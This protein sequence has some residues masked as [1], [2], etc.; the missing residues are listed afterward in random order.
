MNSFVMGWLE[1]V[2]HFHIRVFKYVH[3]IY[4]YIETYLC[5]KAYSIYL[6]FIYSNTL[7]ND[8]YNWCNFLSFLLV[9][10]IIVFLFHHKTEIEMRG[11]ERKRE[12]KSWTWDIWCPQSH[13][14][15]CELGWAHSTP[16]MAYQRSLWLFLPFLYESW[17]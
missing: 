11:R 4:T 5:N 1:P 17:L 7:N 6:S 3:I 9:T 15:L 12:R 2:T 16:K 8:W 10:H 13:D 14:I